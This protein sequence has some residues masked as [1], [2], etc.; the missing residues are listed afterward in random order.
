LKAKAIQPLR[1]RIP[2]LSTA[3]LQA[4][5]PLHAKSWQ[6]GLRGAEV[7]R[8][9]HTAALH[10][11]EWMQL[12][13]QRVRLLI[14]PERDS[15]LRTVEE[16]AWFDFAGQSRLLAFALAYEER[17]AQLSQFVGEALMPTLVVPHAQLG[18]LA[19]GMVFIR[20]QIGGETGLQAQGFLGCMPAMLAQFLA[21]A[22]AVPLAPSTALLATV[23]KLKFSLQLK[24]LSLSAAETMSLRAGDV[25]GLG[26]RALALRDAVLSIQ[27]TASAQAWRCQQVSG[28]WRI[29][30]AAEAQ[31]FISLYEDT[32][33]IDESKDVPAA[34]SPSAQST[35]PPA[36]AKAAA[37]AEADT[38]AIALSQQL[39][40]QIGFELARTSIALNELAQ[41]QPGYVFKLAS[42]LEG[43][44]VRI[45]AN[46]QVIGHGELVSV[47]DFLGVR[48]LAL[49]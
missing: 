28:G 35:E 17:I 30:A 12:S 16:R 15:T 20:Y 40:V 34:Q 2:A 24:P 48:L 11:V 43:Q 22:H 1:G 42:P 38:A 47:G 8:L 14:A 13:S 46:A 5:N 44:N 19:H 10:V 26:A 49:K 25:L 39:E 23:R 6:L 32:M 37:D 45:L 7:L 27:G 3:Q 21:Q 18:K 29:E 9:Q 36:Q 31:E 33:S 41:L 4:T